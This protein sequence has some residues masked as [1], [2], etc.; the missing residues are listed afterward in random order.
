MNNHR[1]CSS[2]CCVLHGCKYGHNDCPV[3]TKSV[4]QEYPCENCGHEG[5][6]SLKELNFRQEAVGMEIR[7]T[8]KKFMLELIDFL[9]SYQSVEPDSTV[10]RAF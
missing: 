1:S 3:V 8:D 9:N 2:H 7:T 4:A 6:D 10:I 5:I